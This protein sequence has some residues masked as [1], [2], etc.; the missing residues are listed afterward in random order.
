MLPIGSKVLECFVFNR[1]YEHLKHLTTDLQHG[2]L[3]NR[4]CVTQI[5]AILHDVGLNLEKNMQTD[6]IIYLDF[7]KAFDSVD[8]ILLAKLNA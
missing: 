1:L 7:A 6:V 4:S 5:L 8:H 3:K 2:F